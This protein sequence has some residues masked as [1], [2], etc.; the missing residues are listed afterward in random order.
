MV[1]KIIEQY[2]EVFDKYGYPAELPELQQ[3]YKNGELGLEA[4]IEKGNIQIPYEKDI[5]S[6]PEKNTAEY[7][8]LKELGEE[9]IRKDEL[10]VA[11]LNGGMAT[12][13]GGCVKG[14]VEVYDRET[15]L[16]LKMKD[17]RNVAA[18]Y[19]AKLPVFIMN[20]FQ[21]EGPTE[22]YLE[23]NQYFGCDDVHLFNQLISVR[24]DEKGEVYIG[25]DG[26]PSLHGPG[27]G[28]FSF[29]FADSGLLEDFIEQGGKHLMFSNCDNLGATVDPAIIGYHIQQ[30]NEMTVETAQKH[31]GDK[32]GAPAYVDGKLQV[33][34][35]F[36]FPE[37]FDQDLIPV[38]N[39]NNFVFDAKV[40]QKETIL[41]WYVAKKKVEN[42]PVVQFE[43]L[44]GELSKDLKTGFITVPRQGVETRFLPI[45]DRNDLE[46]AREIMKEVA[47]YRILP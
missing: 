1:E 17:A 9:A 44:V 33:V 21:T 15:F 3:K 23:D 34:E 40:L 20:S 31:K 8:E 27:H 25:G 37:D 30:G 6:L 19:N 7:R 12:R 5:L 16:G 43:R 11:I 4:N 28:D 47:E 14:V 22:E 18:K 35:G 13:F 38:F 32:G 45:K 36:R 24:L 26:K 10:G 42:Q 39:T 46:K 41:S 2:K 29:A